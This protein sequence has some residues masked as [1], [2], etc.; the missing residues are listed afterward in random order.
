MRKNAMR[1]GTAMIAALA[2]CIG[3]P[4]WADGPA[5]SL[6]PMTPP[7][8][9]PSGAQSVK[10]PEPDAARGLALEAGS[11][12]VLALPGP[13]ANIFVADPK[14]AE[15]RPAS[16]SS[17]FVF[18]VSPGRTTI[19]AMN[20]AGAVVAQYGV[21]VRPSAFGAAEASGNI[22]RVIH[23]AD[24][25][26]ETTPA[27]LTLSG[28]VA[29]AADADQAMAVARSYVQ[30]NQTVDNRL[31]VTSS[32][33]VG[34]RVRIA[35]MSRSIT[36]DL[37][38]NWVALGTIG[39]FTVG[40]ATT[41]GL[42]LAT[43][44]LTALT[45]YN[46]GPV[47]L[48]N[49]ID[50]LAQDN[51]VR[52]LAEPNLTARSGETANFLVGGEYPIPVNQQNNAVSIEYKQY[53]VALSF[54]PTVLSS[55]RISLHVRPEV[56]QLTSNGAVQLSAGNS[57]LQI[58]A[59]TVRR[60]ETTIE[61]GSGDSFAI[62]GLLQDMTT[63]ADNSVMGLGEIPIIGALFRSDNFLHNQTELVI[64]V[65]PYL[66][67]STSDPAQVHLPTDGYVPPS[68]IERILLMRQ[69]ARPPQPDTVATAAR[70]PGSAGFIVQ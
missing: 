19:A 35:E 57:T 56:S 10:L 54:V 20:A 27:G 51:L 25:R 43:G 15:V 11:G 48:S 47:T 23:G 3:G 1:A 37:G 66:V 8:A 9:A 12:K 31:T 61:L 29:T 50:A 55:G 70:V 62:A 36:R 4:A 40:A 42:S 39:R 65:T 49:V 24:V 67:G 13:A 2:G 21:T 60:A 34:L 5:P 58:P 44:G 32:I 53:G 63:Q 18:G 68:D 33:T 6:V 7:A 64:V 22:A 46:T 41:N 69:T 52:V 45:S 30:P 59:L 16:A 28:R 17:I 38:V 14:V 26:V